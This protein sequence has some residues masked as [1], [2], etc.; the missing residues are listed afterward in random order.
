MRYKCVATRALYALRLRVAFF[1][2]SC[3]LSGGVADAVG[4]CSSCG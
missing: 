2:V 1:G 4:V 3:P